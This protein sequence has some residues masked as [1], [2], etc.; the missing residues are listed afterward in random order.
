MFTKLKTSLVSRP[1]VMTDNNE[2]WADVRDDVLA[3]SD[4]VDLTLHLGLLRA[5]FYL[6]GQKL[7]R[8]SPQGLYFQ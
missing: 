4:E 2:D 5:G 6:I 8:N 3:L 1:R 7:H